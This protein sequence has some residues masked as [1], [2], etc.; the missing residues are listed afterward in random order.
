[1]DSTTQFVMIQ[2]RLAERR[3]EAAGER[4]ARHPRCTPGT[5]RRQR[6]TPRRPACSDERPL[7]AEMPSTSSAPMPAAV[8]EG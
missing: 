7:A 2:R 1:M 3:G 6:W 5:F 4:L 8:T